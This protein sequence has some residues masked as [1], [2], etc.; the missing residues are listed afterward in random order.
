MRSKGG[1]W[2]QGVTMMW[3]KRFHSV[4]NKYSN[5]NREGLVTF[6]A[7]SIKIKIRGIPFPRVVEKLVGTQQQLTKL[8]KRHKQQTIIQKYSR[9][10]RNVGTL[11][12]SSY[13]V[14][15]GV[16]IWREATSRA[17]LR[18]NHWLMHAPTEP[19]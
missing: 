17:A 19:Q 13:M 11:L 4:D 16:V 18:T 5:T 7:K 3:E 14:G 9:P 12:Q 6:P 15:K 2:G 8:Q 10:G 1:G